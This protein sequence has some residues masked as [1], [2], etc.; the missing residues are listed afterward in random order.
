M[1]MAESLSEMLRHPRGPV[2]AYLRMLAAVGED[3]AGA[4]AGAE[5]S[6]PFELRDPEYIERTMPA[7][8]LMS[9]LYFRADVTGLDNIPAEGPVLLVG[10]HSG[11]TWIADT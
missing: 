10:N 1:G 8:R 5:D 2:E 3:V 4:L 7:V 6:D 9:K 11:G